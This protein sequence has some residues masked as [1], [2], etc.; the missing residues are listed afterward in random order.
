MFGQ[1]RRLEVPG[2]IVRRE[3][4]GSRQGC[5]H[6]RA[7]EGYGNPKGFFLMVESNNH[8]K[9]VAETLD[10]TVACDRIIR[11]TVQRL[12]DRDT[13]ILVTAD[14]SFD[15]RLPRGPK[16]EPI[17]DKVKV[18]GSHTAEEVLVAAQGPGAARVRGILPN[19]Q[20]FRIM[21]AAYGWRPAPSER[22]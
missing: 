9:N 6:H 21:L 8:S 2:P 10:R 18:E 17:L 16:G 12:G 11:A 5:L 3:M 7:G 15:L 1:E 13:L 20:L 19:T 4:P 22:R 14:H